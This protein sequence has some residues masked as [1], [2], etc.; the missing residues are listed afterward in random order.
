[1]TSEP[2]EA[3]VWIWLPGAGEPVVAGRLDQVGETLQFTYG[4][5]YLARPG[6]IALYL[7]ELPLVED[8]ILPMVGTE[9]GCIGDA[10]PDAWGRRVILNRR[11]G[12][13]DEDTADLSLLSYLLESGSDRVGALDFQESATDYVARDAGSA[14]LA[15]LAQSA[16]LVEQGLPLPPALAEALLRGSSIGGARPKAVLDDGGR[17]LIAKFSSSSDRY[18]VVEA[19]YIAMRLAALAGL[20]VAR[21]ELAEAMGKRVLLVERFY[22]TPG[23]RR[24]A[25]VSALTI[26]GVEVPAAWY[27]S[28]ASLAREIRARFTASAA[29]LEEL[30]GRIT[31]NILTSNTDDHARNHAAFWD[32]TM[33]TLTPAYDICPQP[34][35]GGEAQQVMAIGEDAWRFS[36]V[37]GC[38]ERAATYQLTAANARDI[39]DNQIDVIQS[40]WTEICDEAALD[41]IQRE[42]LWRTQ[43]LN[44]YATYG[45]D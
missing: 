23:G 44:P 29:T 36:Q 18:P 25:L 39:I 17:Q 40:R 20:D 42:R 9:P 33:L 10:A 12:R 15:Q 11:F 4:R 32:G 22:R 19:E 8:P 16:E 37:A 43:F 45:Y 21:V 13:G 34:R 38:V 28:Y 3:F 2:T 5:S 6:A 7:P 1:V 30:F 26:L 24:G 41:R 27:A 14:S 31:F 35:A